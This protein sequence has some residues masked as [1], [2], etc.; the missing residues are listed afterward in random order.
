MRTL[1]ALLTLVL[2]VALVAGC[3]SD[4][5]PTVA[6]C[7]DTTATPSG[8]GGQNADPYGGGYGSPADGGA[9][10]AGSDEPVEGDAVEAVDYEF[11]PAALKVAPGTSV[12]FTNSGDTPHT[13]TADDDSFD[14]GNVDPGD[15]F[16]HTFDAAGTFAFHCEYHPNMEG[17]VTVG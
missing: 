13:F 11:Q 9:S 14:S 15:N 5:T 12:S 1:R 17:T 2:A 7:G 10:G 6:G 8:S 4:D 3:G 16:E